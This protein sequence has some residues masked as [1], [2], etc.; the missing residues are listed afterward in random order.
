[1][2]RTET[3]LDVRVYKYG[4]VCTSNSEKNQ[5]RY[6]IDALWQMNN[7]WNQLVELGEKQRI[8]Y[9][10]ARRDASLEYREL[11]KALEWQEE[12][13]TN[14]YKERRSA[15][16]AAS[17]RDPEHPKIK[18]VVLKI[19][20]LK[21]KRKE[22]WET[23]RPIRAE[24][25][26]L[27][28]PSLRKG[29]NT[30]FNEAC[31]EPLK[32][33]NCDYTHSISAQAIAKNF[34][35][36][37]DTALKNNVKLRFHRFKGEGRFVYPLRKK[38]MSADGISFEDLLNPDILKNKDFIVL[39]QHNKGTGTGK[40]SRS[41]VIRVKVRIKGAPKREYYKFLEFDVI[42]HRPIPKGGI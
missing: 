15:R 25:G 13:I 17:S 34:K 5:P 41:P 28:D 1:M 26:K 31:K 6:L 37:R 7:I 20:Q 42:L 40:K 9:D 8:I 36:M 3:N 35:D 18:P 32:V 33:E 27:I 4:A 29:L 39:D 24:A 38:G 30:D 19:N 22:L 14:A 2:K 12:Q 11:A 21:A 16:A 10:D 23:I